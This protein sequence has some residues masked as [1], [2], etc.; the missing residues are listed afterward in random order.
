MHTNKSDNPDETD[1]FL[2]RS[3]LPKLNH[4][5]RENVNRPIISK[6]IESVIKKS[7]HRWQRPRVADRE[8][9]ISVKTLMARPSF[10]RS[11]PV[12]PLR[13][14]KP[15]STTRRASRPTRSISFLRVNSWR[16][17]AFS[18]TTIFRKRPPCTW[19]FSCRV[20]PSSLP[21]AS[22]PRNTAVTRWSA[23]SIPLG[24]TPTVTCLGKSPHQQP[25]PQEDQIRPPHP[26]ALLL[27][28][29][30][31]PARALR[32][33][34]LNKVFL[35]LTRTVKQKQKH[36]NKKLLTKKSPGPD[37][38]TSKFYQTLSKLTPTLFKLFHEIED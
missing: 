25:V 21:S 18:Q 1:T 26:P 22:W 20:A 17:A 5:E 32:P 24:C 9:Q 7:S 19:S 11:S 38:F 12:T 13:K 36:N 35:S 15:K 23:A 29:G 16:R 8:M 14:L 31:P 2:E 34:D 33:W 6:V 3:N 28:A 30:P 10:S 27:P 37:G 4:E